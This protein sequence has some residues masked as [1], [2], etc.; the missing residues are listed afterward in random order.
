[1]KRLTT[2]LSLILMFGCGGSA[3]EGTATE[4]TD[5]AAHA[6]HAG[7]EEHHGGDHHGEGHHEEA[8]AAPEPT[9]VLAD[10]ARLFGSALDEGR[11]A[12][13]LADIVAE[14]G[15][16]EGQVVKT[17]GEI[18]QVCQARGC[19][20][21]I[22]AAENAPGIRVPM[23]GHSFFLPRDISGRRATL[24]GTVVI[25]ELSEEDRA[26]LEA[27]GAEATDQDVSIEATGVVVH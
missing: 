10:G 18:T 3:A 12:T 19:W 6:E 14:P 11:E 9:E 25:A 8:D 5:E 20:M 13:A 1:M 4:G 26:H 15:R 17:E 21:E 24:E 2:T 16:F 27:E 22:R 7:G 23:A